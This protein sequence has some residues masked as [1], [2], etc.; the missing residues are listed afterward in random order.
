MR[1][2]VSPPYLGA[3]PGRGRSAKPTKPS[4]ANRPRH[5]LT[6]RGIVPTARA[7]DRVER[8][9]AAS[10]PLPQPPASGPPRSAGRS[11]K[12]CPSSR[13][14]GS[15]QGA[16]AWRPRLGSCARACCTDFGSSLLR[17]V[18]NAPQ[19]PAQA[20]QQRTNRSSIRRALS[21]PVWRP[22]PLEMGDRAAFRRIGST[23]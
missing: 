18:P 14:K 19:L 4:R 7:I 16:S 12:E 1:W 22:V 2:P 11:A 21:A 15:C 20:E 9:S 17:L 23:H 5:V 10:N 8:P 6:V 13:A 3:G